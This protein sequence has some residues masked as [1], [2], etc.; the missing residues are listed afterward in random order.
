MADD[1]KNNIKNDRR[2]LYVDPNNLDENSLTNVPVNIE[3]LSIFVE[4]TT[5]KKS[6]SIIS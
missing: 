6:R 1:N 3:D 2:I 5:N 4:L